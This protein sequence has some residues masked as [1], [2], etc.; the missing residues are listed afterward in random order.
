[1]LIKIVNKTG[2][3]NIRNELLNASEICD[4]FNLNMLFSSQIT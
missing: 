2:G 4:K 3:F 1:V